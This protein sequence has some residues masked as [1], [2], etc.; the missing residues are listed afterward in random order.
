[1][2]VAS[3]ATT[4]IGQQQQ[5]KTQAK[6]QRRASVAERQRYLHEVSSMR[7][8]QGQEQVAAAQKMSESARKATE[9]RATARVSAGESGVAGLSVDALIN[10]LTRKEAEYSFNV[11]QQT[12]MNDVNRQLQLR[13]SGIGFTNNLLRINKPIDQPNYI[14]AALSGA[15]T[16]LSTY[17]ALK[18]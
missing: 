17:S 13:D 8:Q 14:G 18:D 9:A 5:A 15:Q 10:D 1:M 2:A 4:V 12:Q 6:A 11:Q 3:T 16:G 7:I